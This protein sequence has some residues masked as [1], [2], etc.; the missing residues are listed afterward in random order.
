MSLVG[1]RDT[2]S[3][4]AFRKVAA[5]FRR[6]VF[7]GLKEGLRGTHTHRHVFQAYFDAC[8]KLDLSA[9]WLTDQRA[10]DD[11][12]S[13][14][15]VFIHGT[16]LNLSSVLNARPVIVDFHT[17]ICEK[18]LGE[19]Y[20]RIMQYERRIT[21]RE[22]RM[23]LEGE[24]E[25]WDSLTFYNRDLRVLMQPWG[26]DLLGDAFLAP[27]DS[28]FSRKIYW[29]GSWWQ[30]EDWG[31]LEEIAG[32]RDWALSKGMDLVL[33]Q[34]C[35]QPRNALFVRNSRIA[36]AIGGRGQ[37]EANYLA[38]RFF[39][40][41]SYGQFCVSNVP[42]AN[43]ILDGTAIYDSRIEN[44]LDKA[45]SVSPREAAELTRFQQDKIRHF[46]VAAHLYILLRAALEF[47]PSKGNA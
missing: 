45:L 18:V 8:R 42:R 36:P 23:P 46:T 32:M 40:N 6:I 7:W 21:E 2:Y 13:D 10:S 28:F 39:K 38:C 30:G 27:A 47:C 15:I 4:Q 1:V 33:F 24:T 35:D 16:N 19:N 14:D 43:E 26:S 31:N 3:E 29:M 25:Q 12:S 11:I 17:D 44:M 22:R 5:S 34:D 9:V 41:I 37:V 20:K